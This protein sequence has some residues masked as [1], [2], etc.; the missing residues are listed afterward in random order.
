[1]TVSQGL[2]LLPH[3]P[4]TSGDGGVIHTGSVTVNFPN[5]GNY[6]IEVDWDYWYHSGRTLDVRVNGQ[7]ISL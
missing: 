4:P 2:P 1:M 5:A 3:T 6:P 7:P